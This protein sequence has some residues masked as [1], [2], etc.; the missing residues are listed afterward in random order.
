MNAR[1][2]A[3]LFLLLLLCGCSTPRSRAPKEVEDGSRRE[4]HP[5]FTTEE[6]KAI[7]AARR[8]IEVAQNRGRLDLYY[9]VTH[10]PHST[11][12]D[13]VVTA[14]QV[15]TYL[16]NKPAFT[17]NREWTVEVWDGVVVHLSK[18]ML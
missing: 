18:T 15:Y 1:A 13:Y 2:I 16:N 7:A 3:V 10:L 5:A 9:K 8:C 11:G 14:W 12:N 6:R 4:N 17:F